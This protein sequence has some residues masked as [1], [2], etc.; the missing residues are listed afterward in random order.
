MVGTAGQRRIKSGR[1]G[2]LLPTLRFMRSNTL[3]ITSIFIINF[4]ILN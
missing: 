4:M 2:R 1:L 3:A